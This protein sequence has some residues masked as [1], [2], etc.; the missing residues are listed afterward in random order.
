[1]EVITFLLSG[2]LRDAQ[3]GGINHTYSIFQ[4]HTAVALNEFVRMLFSKLVVKSL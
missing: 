3:E 1:M 2:K 4:I